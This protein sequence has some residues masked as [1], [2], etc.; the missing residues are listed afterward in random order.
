M[1]HSHTICDAISMIKVVSIT[2]KY[3]VYKKYKIVNTL[4]EE[5]KSGPDSFPGSHSRSLGTRPRGGMRVVIT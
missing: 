5:S 4:Q 3:T 2:V 1:V